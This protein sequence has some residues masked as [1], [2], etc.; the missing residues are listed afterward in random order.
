VLNGDKIMR[1][2]AYFFDIDG[3]LLVTRDLVHWNALHQAMLEVYGVD[4]TIEGIAYHGKTDVGILRAALN[5]AGVS[6]AAFEK[7]LAAA[8]AVICREVEA[9]V[10]G[11]QA[12][13]CPGIPEVLT[14][15][16]GLK[17]LLGVASGNLESVGWNKLRAAGLRDFF[18]LAS[19]GDRWEMR[20]AIFDQAV[21]AAKK[22]LGN[23][24][25]VCFVGDTPE[26]IRAAKAVNA[27]VV[28]VCTG[29]FCSEQL[30]PHG[31]D[32]CCTSCTELLGKLQ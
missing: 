29:I 14:E 24:A 8:L 18:T 31:P 20:S 4:T 3:T 6:E 9:H 17:K 7:G 10:D 19:F 26:D 13:V 25:V 28:A 2:D 27:K 11:I 30:S 12:L 16:Q 23:D 22:S 21:T 5:R 1:A 15:V 32:V